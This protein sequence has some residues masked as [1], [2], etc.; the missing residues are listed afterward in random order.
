MPTGRQKSCVHRDPHGAQLAALTASMRHPYRSIHGEPASHWLAP[1][2]DLAAQ[3]ITAER[4]PQL[5]T[6]APPSRTMVQELAGYDSCAMH[7]ATRQTQHNMNAYS[8]S[9]PQPQYSPDYGQYHQLTDVSGL[10]Q[11]MTGTCTSAGWPGMYV[12]APAAVGPGRSQ[13][14]LD[15]WSAF[16][17]TQTMQG[18]PNPGYGY[19]HG[20]MNYGQ[21]THTPLPVTSL[22]NLNHSPET[23]GMMCSSPGSNAIH[24]Y[25]YS[26]ADRTVTIGWI[27]RSGKDELATYSTS[28]LSQRQ[29]ALIEF[30][31][32]FRCQQA[33]A[34]G[35][36]EA[37]LMQAFSR[38]HRVGQKRGGV[39]EIGLDAP[40]LL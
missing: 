35:L 18:H 19:R 5:C 24:T 33:S 27:K 32:G 7:P 36:N 31:S 4:R 15:D 6:R 10:Q 34:C 11:S 3:P 26:V 13:S 12:G 1:P 30:A 20:D 39:G 2:F 28:A 29:A 22:P 16:M 9:G 25:T 38:R 37:E 17:T 23:P 8:Y 40:R 14:G 21:N